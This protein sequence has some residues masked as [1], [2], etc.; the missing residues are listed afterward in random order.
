MSSFV[1]CI[2]VIGPDNSP[3][4]VHK[5]IPEKQDFE[6]DTLLFCS[7]DCF[8]NQTQTRRPPNRNP[9]RFLGTI[10]SA[11]RF[12]IWGYKAVMGYRILVLTSIMQ[13]QESVVRGIC[14]KVKDVLLETVLDPF[15][16]PFSIIESAIAK[17]KIASLAATPP[18]AP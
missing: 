12:L 2:A 9:D 5:A 16:A 6:F 3:L 7:L 14:E 17:E 4:L 18:S 1:G 15:Y 10:Q 11:E 8:E 13:N